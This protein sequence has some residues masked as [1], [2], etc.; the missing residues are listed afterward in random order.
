MRSMTG[1]GRSV[2]TSTLGTL[3]T[4]IRS[5]NHRYCQVGFRMPS[6]F[7]EFETR[8]T[9]LIK[10][11]ASRGQINVN[12]T[13]HA[14]G[15]TARP[16]VT[17]NAALARELFSQIRALQQ[18]VGIDEPL[19]VR[20][21]IALP[22]V[23]D[24]QHPEIDAEERWRLLEKGLKEAWDELVLMRDREG[25]SLKDEMTARL[26]EIRTL[27][28]EIG[29]EMPDLIEH[30]RE[31]LT[32]RIQDLLKGNQEVDE[33][34]IVMEAGLLADKADVSEEIA[35]L[36]SHC[37]QFDQ[38]LN[39]DGST[40]RQMDFLLQEMN[41]EANT[42]G[43]KAANGEVVSRCVALKTAIERLREQAQNVE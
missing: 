29:G 16:L 22:G 32:K 23:I 21:V 31:R 35:R 36:E 42:I 38:Y 26:N 25:A 39:E 7:S 9:N 27:R 34:R 24:A 5:V 10:N 37:Q 14:D 40:G 12:V 17:I 41:R 43:S 33:M 8:A 19:S 20:D 13:F 3:T 18:A 4:E 6:E 1:F 15:D 2:V 30:Y 28:D 11:S